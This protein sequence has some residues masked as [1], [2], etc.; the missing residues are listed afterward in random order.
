MQWLRSMQAPIGALARLP[1]LQVVYLDYYY[2]NQ[3]LT[4]QEVEVLQSTARI[5][6]W[7][8][9]KTILRSETM[10]INKFGLRKTLNLNEEIEIKCMNYW[11][12][13]R[14]KLIQMEDHGGHE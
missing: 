2:E 10:K 7:Y 9:T 14:N 8:L 13:F 3:L 11:L 1:M 4:Q 5:H 6:G 12:Q